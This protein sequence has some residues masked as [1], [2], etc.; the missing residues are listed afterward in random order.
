MQYN[1][2]HYQVGHQRTLKIITHHVKRKYNIMSATLQH[3]VLART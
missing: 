2:S 3:R 1:H